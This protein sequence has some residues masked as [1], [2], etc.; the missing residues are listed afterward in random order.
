MAEFPDAHEHFKGSDKSC[1]KKKQPHFTPHY[2]NI[3]DHRAPLFLACLIRL[4]GFQEARF[5]KQP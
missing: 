4:P 5:G 2:T 3:F 1:I